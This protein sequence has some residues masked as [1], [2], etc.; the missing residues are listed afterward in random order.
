MYSEIKI[1]EKNFIVFAVETDNFDFEMDFFSNIIVNRNGKY[2]ISTKA[3]SRCCSRKLLESV[4]AD[5][6][7]KIIKHC[8]ERAEIIFGDSE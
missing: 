4:K 2:S 1:L 8:K 6:E 7:K 5:A 3:G